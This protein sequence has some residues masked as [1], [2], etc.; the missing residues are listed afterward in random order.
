MTSLHKPLP[1]RATERVAYQAAS[2][3]PKRKLTWRERCNDA[4]LNPLDPAKQA[5]SLSPGPQVIEANAEGDH[6]AQAIVAAW[7]PAW[8]FAH[9]IKQEAV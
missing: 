7:M 1:T 3:Q 6:T 9:L 2:K 4:K 5:A 8:G